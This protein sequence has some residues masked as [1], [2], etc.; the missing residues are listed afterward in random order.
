MI[1]HKMGFP[2]ISTMGLG[3]T[4]VSSL[5]RVPS[6]PARITTFVLTTRNTLTL[7]YYYTIYEWMQKMYLGRNRGFIHAHPLE[8]FPAE[9]GI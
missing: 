1:C 5:R 3:L 6:P 4:T 9:L 7:N 2:P 8:N